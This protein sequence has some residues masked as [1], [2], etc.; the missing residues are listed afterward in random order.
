MDC[1][2]QTVKYKSLCGAKLKYDKKISYLE[3]FKKKSKKKKV[4]NKD[5]KKKPC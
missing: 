2:A 3:G 1:F 4:K 5:G